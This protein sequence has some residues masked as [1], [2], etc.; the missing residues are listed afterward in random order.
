[1]GADLAGGGGGGGGGSSTPSNCKF[2]ELDM[3]CYNTNNIDARTPKMIAISMAKANAPRQVI[4]K[5][6]CNSNKD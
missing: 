3:S 5:R 4:E 1:M 2:Y 6:A